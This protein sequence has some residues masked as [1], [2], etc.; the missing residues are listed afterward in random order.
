M[1]TRYEQALATRGFS[2]L[3]SAAFACTSVSPVLCAEFFAPHKDL[4][5]RRIQDTKQLHTGLEWLSLNVI[6]N[7]DRGGLVLIAAS[8]AATA[9]ERVIE[10]LLALGD[11]DRCSQLC[12]FIICQLENFTSYPWVAW[13]SSA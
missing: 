2:E 12:A 4:L 5:G 6:P 13:A 7:G 10:S 3:N 8:G 9:Y 11:A 1:K